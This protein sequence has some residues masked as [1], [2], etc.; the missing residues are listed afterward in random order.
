LKRLIILAGL[1]AP[2]FLAAALAQPGEVIPAGAASTAENLGELP[3][4]VPPEIPVALLVDLAT[5]QTL[6]SREADRRFVPASVTKVMTA[7]TAFDLVRD[8]KIKLDQRIHIT[9]QLEKEWSGEGST[10]FL[11]AGEQPTI[12]QLLLGITTVSANDGAVALAV[13]S[14]GSIDGWLK[15]MNE[16]AAQLGMKNT[17]FG[18][19]NGWPD[20]GRTYTSARDLALL[21]EALTQRYPGLYRRFFGKPGMTWRNISQSNHDP[22]SRRIEGADGI[23]TG[24]TNQAG[25]NFL[26]SAE[27][28]G[29]RLIMVL[30]GAPSSHVR[31]DAARALMKWGFETFEPR[32]LVEKS[33]TVG[34]AQVQGGDSEMVALQTSG[35]VMASQ[36]RTGPAAVSLT[37]RYRGPL[38]APIAKGETV[39]T[40]RVSVTG[41]ESHDFPL[42][43]A[44]RVEVANPW[45]R[46]VHGLRKFL[47]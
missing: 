25:Y 21:A 41:Q 2:L 34:S 4:P 18:T 43:A 38:K 31:D 39:G 17:H 29:R 9:D 23:K 40:L 36:P 44:H 8:G 20:E 19:A 15:L 37:I 24:F 6:Y 10:M 13:T 30:A 27:R 28:N 22:I 45:Q 3:A 16:N 5:G 1:V 7:Y 47:T 33:A 35:V 26:G 12:G 32:R 11:K 14:A 46:L 42:I